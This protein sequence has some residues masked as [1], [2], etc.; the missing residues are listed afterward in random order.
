MVLVEGTAEGREVRLKFKGVGRLYRGFFAEKAGVQALG[1]GLAGCVAGEASVVVTYDDTHRIGRIVVDVPVQALTCHG[2]LG[3]DGL[4]LSGL[5]PLGKAVAAWRDDIASKKDLRVWSF[6]VGVA[7][8]D[9]MGGAILWARGQY[10]TDGSTFSPCVGVDGIE[11]CAAGE[12][13]DGTSKLS[14]ADKK[15]GGRVETLLLPR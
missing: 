10:P 14:F 11:R 13:R 1:K 4:E 12:R 8:R 9:G 7:V 5:A 3:E 2:A 6:K 15:V